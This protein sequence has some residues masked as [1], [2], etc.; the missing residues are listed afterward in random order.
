M[1]KKK[2]EST[3]EQFMKAMAIEILSLRN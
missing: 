1:K 2:E 3:V